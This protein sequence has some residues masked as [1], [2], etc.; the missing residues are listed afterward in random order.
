MFEI[1]LI[2][3]TTSST[4][5]FLPYTRQ[6]FRRF[7]ESVVGVEVDDIALSVVFELPELVKF[8]PVHR[9]LKEEPNTE[10]APNTTLL[11]PVV[12]VTTAAVELEIKNNWLNDAALRNRFCLIIEPTPTGAPPS[13]LAFNDF[14]ML[15]Q[16]ASRS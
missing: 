1:G 10:S 11:P 6:R 5:P 3:L 8:K 15:Q 7:P 14:E 9:D 2:V 16:S 13:S 12:E 4:F